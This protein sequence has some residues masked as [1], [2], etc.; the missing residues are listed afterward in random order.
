MT[1]GQLAQLLGSVTVILAL[2]ISHII[3]RLANDQ[4]VKDSDSELSVISSLQPVLIGMTE[5]GGNHL[6]VGGN[7][8]K[9]ETV[10]VYFWKVCYC[11][12]IATT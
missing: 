11:V 10:A 3:I 4:G 1:R 8:M 9:R 2:C 7:G 5:G 6:H 12:V